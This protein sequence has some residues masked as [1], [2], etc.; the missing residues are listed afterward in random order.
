MKTILLALLCIVGCP[1]SRAQHRSSHHYD[2]QITVL[3]NQEMLL[4]NQ[5]N[6]PDLKYQSIRRHEIEQQLQEIRQQKIEIEKI[7]A[8]MTD[9]DRSAYPAAPSRFY[10]PLQPETPDWTQ[11]ES[12]T[13]IV[14]GIA[15]IGDRQGALVSGGKIVFSNEVFAT[16]YKNKTYYW[17]VTHIGEDSVDFIE[18]D[19]QGVPIEEGRKDKKDG[20]RN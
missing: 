6:S 8:G 4:L 19:R 18:V 10:T 5:L 17:R 16:T 2:I 3:K 13:V 15:T 14:K 20:G 11:I 12:P 7:R 9:S 1:N